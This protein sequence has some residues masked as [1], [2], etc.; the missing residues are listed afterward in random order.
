MKCNTVRA[1]KIIGACGF[2]VNLKIVLKTSF[3]YY[4]Q[5]IVLL[6]YNSFY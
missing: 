2:M 1:F 6:Y 5:Q 4:L 3:P